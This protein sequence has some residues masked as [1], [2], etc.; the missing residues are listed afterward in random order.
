MSFSSKV[1]E[2]RY[3]KL[4]AEIALSGLCSTSVC[5]EELPL[6]VHNNYTC[7]PFV[8]VHN[9]YILCSQS[10]FL[11]SCGLLTHTCL[12]MCSEPWACAGPVGILPQGGRVPE[13]ECNVF[14]GN[15]DVHLILV[16]LLH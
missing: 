1:K 7:V 6:V 3:R 16:L 15:T 4:K 5:A 2:V 14:H 11:L 12:V 9:N 13:Q 8:V 10:R